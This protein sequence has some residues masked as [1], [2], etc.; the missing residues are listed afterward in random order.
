MAK[1]TYTQKGD[2]FVIYKNKRPLKTPK[3]TPVVSK[4]EGLAKKIVLAL[5]N[6]EDYT[7]PTSILCY[8]YTY[9]ELE[10]T[11][12]RDIIADDLISHVTMEALMQ[13][14]YLMYR[15]DTPMK[16]VVASSMVN[17]VTKRIRTFNLYE[18]TCYLVIWT[19]FQSWMLSHYIFTDIIY[20]LGNEEACNEYDELKE[21]FLSYL[22]DYECGYFNIDPDDDV[23][24]KHAE[25][26][27]YIVDAFTYYFLVWVE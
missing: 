18:L 17:I 23:F 21:E 2:E 9:L 4:Y 14:D 19:T 25:G 3:G 10:K 11:Y 20:E 24:V 1:F 26:M 16:H 22:S 12:G 6:N 5:E 8:H 7:S 15:Q 27:E 13:D